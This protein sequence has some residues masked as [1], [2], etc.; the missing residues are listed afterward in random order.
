M[1]CF[2]YNLNCDHRR[3]MDMAEDAGELQFRQWEVFIFGDPT[4]QQWFKSKE[5]TEL[6]QTPAVS[7]FL[8]VVLTATATVSLSCLQ[9]P[10]S[11]SMVKDAGG[12]PAWP[13]LTICLFFYKNETICCLTH[14]VWCYRAQL[15]KKEKKKK[16]KLKTNNF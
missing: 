16:K 2:I 15:L 4:Q 11:S 8:S 7:D 1:V 12:I 6:D 14:T 3:T 13:T 9:V 10:Q 5:E